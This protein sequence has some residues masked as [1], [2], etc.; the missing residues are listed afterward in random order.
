MERGRAAGKRPLATA[1]GL[2]RRDFL[3]VGGA[4]LAG[5]TLL[6][7]PLA[8]CNGA[9]Q[10]GDGPARIIFSFGPDDSGTLEEL[11]DRFNREHE[12]EIE[13]EYREMS[14]ITD[15]YFDEVTSDF[16]AGVSPPIDVIGG[17]VIWN[18][19]FAS[20]G[21]L[22]DITRRMYTD[23]SPRVPDAFLQA[24]ITS[25]SYENKFWGVPWFTDA[26]LLYY[27]QDLLEESGFDGPPETWDELVEMASQ[28]MDDAGTRYGF[29]FQGD[30]YEGGVVNGLEFIWNAGGNVLTGNITVNDPD[31]IFN[32]TPNQ[33]LINNPDSIRGLEIE[34]G[35][36]EEGISPEEVAG[37]R[38]EDSLD[39]F[40]AGDAV[41]LRG[42]PF[43][44]QIFG[45][46]GQ[47]NQDQVGIAPLPVAEPGLQSFSCLGGWNMYVNRDSQN[48][49]AA[50]TFIKFMTA[51]EQQKFRAIEGSFLPT[52]R[53][54][55]DDQEI[56]DEVPVIQRGGTVVRNNSRSRPATPFYSQI[57]RRLAG[58]FNAN[59]RGEVSP[60]ETVQR[61]QRELQTIVE[62]NR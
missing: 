13:V 35:L 4:G 45:Q 59:L 26:G 24:P 53:E 27:R 52:L 17:D 58:A 29:V 20:N 41:F 56:L 61:L 7:G 5:A 33:I 57:S 38:E 28:V 62:A 6:G 55:Y 19:E 39:A 47:V 18:A 37:F 46:E 12:G 42:W 15:E 16:G 22:E 60:E 34:R 30:D 36:V 8:G 23:Y 2:S 50:W 51:P 9:G 32:I 10:Q 14:R 3:K 49:D 43:M 1:K 31:K 54:L 44:Y 21:W 11:V 40:N 48:I 25:V